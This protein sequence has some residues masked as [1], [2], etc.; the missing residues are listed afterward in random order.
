MKIVCKGMFVFINLNFCCNKFA[1][2]YGYY[3]QPRGKIINFIYS[4]KDLFLSTLCYF[5]LLFEKY[6]TWTMITRVCDI[7]PWETVLDI[8]RQYLVIN[9]K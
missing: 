1:T 2:N 5:K 4:F 3:Y 7:E 8:R 9:I 6:P